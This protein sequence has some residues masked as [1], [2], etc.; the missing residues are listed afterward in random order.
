MTTAQEIL[1]KGIK[2]F[3]HLLASKSFREVR[4]E[5]LCRRHG[6]EMEASFES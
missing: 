5:G 2:F 3:W 4:N 6:K 1:S